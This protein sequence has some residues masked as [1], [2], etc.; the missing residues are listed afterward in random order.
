MASS[1]NVLQNLIGTGLEINSVITL[2]V[3]VLFII[4]LV[5][6]F[7]QLLL[8]TLVE[9]YLF[10]R[11]RGGEGACFFRLGHKGCNAMFVLLWVAQSKLM[12]MLSLAITTLRHYLN[13]W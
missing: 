11:D 6:F 2:L 1:C 7:F 10:L 9:L 4:S 3:L 8:S 12:E 13:S 5:V